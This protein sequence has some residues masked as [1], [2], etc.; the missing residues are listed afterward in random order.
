[1]M[2][3]W[4]LAEKTGPA[5]VYFDGEKFRFVKHTLLDQGKDLPPDYLISVGKAVDFKEVEK[6]GTNV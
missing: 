6:G 5:I 1:V 3:N 2:I 4:K